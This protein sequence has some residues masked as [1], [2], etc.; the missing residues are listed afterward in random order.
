MALFDRTAAATDG[1]V[2]T[3]EAKRARMLAGGPDKPRKIDMLTERASGVLL[4]PTSI[5]T[6]FGIGDLGP[7]AWEFLD[8][9]AGAGQRYWQVLPLCPADAGGSPYQLS[10]IHI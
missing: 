5:P 10:L 1:S 3:L 8:W 9:L 7:R 4:H 6:R 2:M